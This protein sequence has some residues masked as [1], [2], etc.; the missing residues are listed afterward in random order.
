MPEYL[1]RR[2]F[3]K[4]EQVKL[5]ADAAVI[6]FLRFLKLEQILRQLLFRRP[7][8]AVDTLQH[9]IT[10]VTPPIRPGELGQLEAHADF[11]GARR[12]RPQ[13][14]IKELALPVD[15][16]DLTLRQVTDDLGLVVFAQSLEIGDRLIARPF[17]ANERLI[18]ADDF[19]HLLF[20]LGKIVEGEGLIAGK[21][22]VKAGVDRRTDRHLRFREQCLDGLGHDMGGV[23][24]QQF[25]TLG[26]FTRDDR[27]PGIAVDDTRQV[28]QLTVY[29]DGER[30]LGETGANRGRDGGTGHRPVEHARR[31]IRQGQC[32]RALGGGRNG[33][34]M[35]SSIMLNE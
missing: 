31:A 16:N 3:L 14:E 2:F 25:N 8:G 10:A 12:M 9:R 11:A 24:A 15:R 29:L 23:V 32:D 6:A 21:I 20:D 17:L 5:A 35:V 30:R 33:H 1:T 13:A 34:G 26:L 22:V 28:A 4:V 19:A 18:G 27:D 7:G